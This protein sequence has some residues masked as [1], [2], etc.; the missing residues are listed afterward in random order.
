MDIEKQMEMLYTAHSYF[1]TE[2]IQHTTDS[3]H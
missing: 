2:N 3:N 1:S